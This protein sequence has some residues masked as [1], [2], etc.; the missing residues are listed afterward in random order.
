MARKKQEHD[1][2]VEMGLIDEPSGIIR[3][4]I[5]QEKIEELAESIKAI[6]Q[7][8]AILIRP[9]DKRYEIVFGHRR[10]LAA[11]RLG[12]ARIRATIKDL[13]DA[14]T[15]LMRA[16][17]NIER[18]H[19]TPI[20]EAVVYKDLMESVGM[21]IKQVSK[22]MGK[23]EAIIKR[24][25][26]LLKMPPCLQKAVHEREIGYSVAEE[27]WRLKDL[28]DI[29]YYLGYAV[30]HGATQTVVRMW[31]KEKIAERRR[32]EGG[33]VE[34]GQHFAP[35]ETRPVYVSC[36]MCQ[37]PM[38][39]GQETVIRCCPECEKALKKAMEGGD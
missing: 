6:G 2:M 9:K 1:E 12:H 36:D 4:E 19:I 30:D 16:T 10:F 39:I 37:G 38:E 26:D 33:T 32:Q 27:L 3:M 17:E 24:R 34:G 29:E 35:L 15:A 21:T 28:N 22:R 5:D 13:D 23:S 7:L 31:V 20:E 14:T 25:V 8:Q 18:E 11:Q